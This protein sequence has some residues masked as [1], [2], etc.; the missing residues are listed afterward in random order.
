MRPLS[1]R[2]VLAGAMAAGS[3][4]S[5][6]SQTGGEEEKSSIGGQVIA[7]IAI[8]QMPNIAFSFWAFSFWQ[9]ASVF[10]CRPWQVRLEPTAP[11]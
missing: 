10:G 5:A 2:I 7:G 4:G 1:R 3:I 11:T 8:E 9:C 6:W